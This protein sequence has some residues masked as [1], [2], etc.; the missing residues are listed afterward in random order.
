MRNSNIILNCEQGSDEW[1]AARV[2]LIS[3]SNLSKLITST[4][5]KST[6][7]KTYLNGL[8]AEKIMGEKIETH[9]TDAMKRGV[10]LE[11]EARQAYQLITDNVVNEVG[12]IYFDDNKRLSCSP[13]GLMA[14]KGLEIKC[15]NPNT[16]IKYLLSGK[17]PSEY[18]GQVQGSM[19]VTGLKQWDFMSYHPNIKPFIITVEQDEEWQANLAEIVKDS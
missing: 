16:H 18:Y 8:I 19:Y 17:C 14:N 12:L 1:F 6:S 9:Q 13:D 11:E 2:G 15:P 7:A 10:E 3:A 4:G 5:K